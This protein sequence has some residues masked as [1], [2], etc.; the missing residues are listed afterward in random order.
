[1]HVQRGDGCLKKHAGASARSSPPGLSAGTASIL[2]TIAFVKVRANPARLHWR[3][4]ATTIPPLT[5]ERT[6][7]HDFPN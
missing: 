4:R 6:Q 1:M 7:L 2:R 5:V 3:H